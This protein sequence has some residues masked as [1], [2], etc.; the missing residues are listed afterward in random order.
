VVSTLPVGSYTFIVTYG[1]DTNFAT[2]SS[3]SNT[4]IVNQASTATTLVASPNP[5]VLGQPVSLTAT[6][7]VVSPGT[8]TATGSV[9]FKD[10]TTT[11]GT[12]TLTNGTAALS[13][14]SLAL[15]S[16]SLTAS[17]GGSTTFKTS[18]TTAT[19]TVNQVSTTTTLT[20]SPN[21]STLGQTV[22]LTAAVSPVAPG[23]GTATGTVTF[24][25]GTTVLGTATLASGSA[26]VTI[27]TLVAGAHSLTAS[28]SGSTNFGTSTSAAVTQTVDQP[29]TTTVLTPTPSPSTFGQTVTLKATVAVVAPGTGTPTGV[30][31]FK[32]GSTT[33]GTATL[34]GG[35]ASFATAALSLGAHSLTAAYGGATNFS[36]STSAVVTQTVN[37]PSSTIVLTSNL[38]P[39]VYGQ[40]VTLKAVVSPV[41]PGTGTPDGTV[42]FKDGSTVIGTATLSGGAAITAVSS[43]T[44]GSHSL[45]AMYGGSTSF[46]AS[47]SSVVTQTVN[48]ASTAT[49]LNVSPLSS[50][51]G[52]PVTVTATVSS[53]SVNMTGTVTFKDGAAVLGTASVS[54]GTASLIVTT[55]SPTIHLLTASYAGDANYSSSASSIALNLVSQASS[56][57]EVVP[58]ANPSKFG[59]S[60]TLVGTVR[61][62]AP[63][64]GTPTGSLT[65][66]DGS[67]TIGTVALAG[68]TASLAISS[69][70]VGNHSITAVYNDDSNF[71]TSTSPAVTQV[72]SPA[73]TSIVLT[74]SLNP[75]NFGQTVTFKATVSAVSPGGGTPTGSVV[76]KDG[77]STIGT[78]TVSNGVA[79]L[80][81]SSLSR[82]TH[83]ITA[84]FQDGG[85][86]LASTSTAVTQT[87]R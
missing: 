87:V 67:T 46:A 19:Q 37:L 31:T 71:G 25:D 12:V 26:A 58:S 40:S 70:S 8:G 69:L 42:T 86:Y 30:V 62:V 47:T 27:S 68:G 74:S 18:S 45:T 41:S 9:T 15:G 78:V 83:T 36:G 76:F 13:I 5:S 80:S 85:S 4:A 57:T 56:S 72:V 79:N 44:G 43:L 21:P 33:L 66:R 35:I 65:F 77:S 20:A 1:G 64:V 17:Y 39:S 84:A 24:R 63:S 49:G 3:T 82:G 29:S 59:Q 32:D 53:S 16:H 61:P 6:V 7:A 34:S 75:S 14:S 23:T 73:S 52:Q 54:G 48:K 11:L 81:I 22:T 50:V 55:L 28:Y 60:I 2:S 38:N 10:G 51:F